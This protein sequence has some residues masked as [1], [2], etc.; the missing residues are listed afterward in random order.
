[1]CA[2][3]PWASK[4]GSTKTKLAETVGYPREAATEQSITVTAE[5]VERLVREHSHIHGVRCGADDFV[6]GAYAN[7]APSGET[8]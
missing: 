2:A 5:V 7:L 3:S 4:A 6:P 1:M 8:G